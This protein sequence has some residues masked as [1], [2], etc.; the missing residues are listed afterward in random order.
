[1]ES[2]GRASGLPDGKHRWCRASSASDESDESK[3]DSRAGKWALVV[4][5]F[6]HLPPVGRFLNPAN[7]TT[8]SITE[9]LLRRGSKIPV[10]SEQHVIY[11]LDPTY[12]GDLRA[13]CRAG[14]SQNLKSKKT[15]VITTLA[16][17]VHYSTHTC[18]SKRISI[19]TILLRVT[20]APGLVLLYFRLL[21]SS[22]LDVERTTSL[23]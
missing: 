8:F 21:I 11:P 5:L 17:S 10:E 15:A 3:A 13:R 22:T 9:N 2:R 6:S 7:M 19:V 16:K 14:G 18:N 1:L 20:C 23:W 12:C 4:D